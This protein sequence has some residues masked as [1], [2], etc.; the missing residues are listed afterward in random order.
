MSVKQQ[1]ILP[2]FNCVSLLG[3]PLNAYLVIILAGLHLNPT[4][5]LT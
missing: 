3:L 4:I 2:Y 1:L 5:K